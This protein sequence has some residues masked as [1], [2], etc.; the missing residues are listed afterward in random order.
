MLKL[1]EIQKSFVFRKPSYYEKVPELL[2]EKKDLKTI[3]NKMS[4]LS[5]INQRCT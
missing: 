2:T 3:K 1:E 4:E 5:E